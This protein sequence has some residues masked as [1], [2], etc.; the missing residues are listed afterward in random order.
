KLVNPHEIRFP[1]LGIMVMLF[2]AIVNI[3]VSRIIKK[4][5][6]EANSVAMK[7]NALHLYTDVF[8]SLGIAL[9]LFLVY[10]T[11]WLWLDP[12]I[13]ILTAFYIM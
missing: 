10:I 13:A 1:A 12:V 8:T 2:G 5:A 3:I 11:G 4:A 7:S 9:S 6:D